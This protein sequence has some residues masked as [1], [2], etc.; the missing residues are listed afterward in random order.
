MFPWRSAQS[1]E[2]QEAIN[3]SVLKDAPY[4]GE[5]FILRPKRKYDSNG[6]P[7]KRKTKVDIIAFLQGGAQEKIL[8]ETLWIDAYSL[9]IVERMGTSTGANIKLKD[10]GDGEVFEI[11]LQFDPATQRLRIG[12]LSQNIKQ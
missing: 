2:S 8:D 12:H 1:G 7:Q 11:S 3:T 9:D 4:R 6:K 10:D 5:I